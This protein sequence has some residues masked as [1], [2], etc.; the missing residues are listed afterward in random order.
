MLSK[1]EKDK[2]NERRNCNTKLRFGL[3]Q[4]TGEDA[5]FIEAAD[6]PAQLLRQNAS[7]D[8]RRRGY[9]ALAR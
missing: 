9:D 6:F 4:D 8:P 2:E 5:L 3:L 7:I 1:L